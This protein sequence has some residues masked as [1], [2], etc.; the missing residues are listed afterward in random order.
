MIDD[1]T[2]IPL[3]ERRKDHHA[4]RDGMRKHNRLMEQ[5]S[6]GESEQPS[7]VFVPQMPHLDGPMNTERLG[8]RGQS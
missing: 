3:P 8:R 1:T 6:A 2:A 7:V 5:V 4:T